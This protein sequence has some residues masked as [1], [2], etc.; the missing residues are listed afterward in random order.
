M[1]FLK[2]F[3]FL[4]SVYSLLILVTASQAEQFTN[5]G[6]F[7]TDG[8]ALAGMG[9]HTSAPP[10][11]YSGPVES[12]L[13]GWDENIEWDWV[14]EL[15]GDFVPTEDEPPL[16][17][18]PFSSVST[19]FDLD[20]LGE[21]VGS[22]GLA[23]TGTITIDLNAGSAIVD[24]LSGQVLTPYSLVETYEVTNTSGSFSTLMYQNMRIEAYGRNARRLLAGQE[25]AE[26]VTNPVTQSSATFYIAGDFS[27]VP[28]P[29]S[30]M[31]LVCLPFLSLA[32][33]KR[34]FA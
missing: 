8:P 5:F 1:T 15:T 2:T 18:A 26:A 30:M 23:G 19:F 32:L 28:E 22:L 14:A 24:E 33:R 13:P 4:I 27:V 17:A 3:P 9:R 25:I 11:W 31:M 34:R 12:A 7:Y 10:I 16:L 21:V 20:E 6:V 29:S